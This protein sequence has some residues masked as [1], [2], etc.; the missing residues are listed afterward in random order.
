MEFRVF[1]GLGLYRGCRVQGLGFGCRVKGFIKGSMEPYELMCCSRHRINR[2]ERQALAWWRP[3]TQPVQLAERI[4][5]FW[6]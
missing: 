5:L 6:A 3:F 2:Q 4:K 1:V